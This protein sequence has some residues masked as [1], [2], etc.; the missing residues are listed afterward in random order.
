MVARWDVSHT[1][2]L[3]EPVLG[4]MCGVPT[5]QSLG[6]AYWR[7]RGP[8]PPDPDPDR[9]RCGL[10]WYAP[11]APASGRSVARLTD[12]ATDT[13]LEY[14]FEPMIS[15]TMLTPRTISC[16]ISI[17]YDRDINAQDREARRCY[18]SLVARCTAEGYYPY[19]LG[20]QSLN[21]TGHHAS[22]VDLIRRL[23]KTLDPNGILAPGRYDK[24]QS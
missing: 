19:R 14:G 16:V 10:M 13:L 9:D 18:D 2:S 22:Y 23:K 1:V 7:R 6:S 17:T 8:V 15:L 12:I 20:I 21:D 3:I 5:P 24:S 4:L 11:V